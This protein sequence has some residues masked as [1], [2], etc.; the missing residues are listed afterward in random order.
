MQTAQHL[1]RAGFGKSLITAMED[2][3]S[4]VAWRAA[5]CNELHSLGSR[6]ARVADDIPTSFPNPD[7][8]GLYLN[9]NTSDLDPLSVPVSGNSPDLASLARFAEEHFVWGD[10]CGILKKFSTS[11][12]PG[13][14]VR[15]LV[16][17]AA[18]MDLGLSGPHCPIIDKIL[19]LRAP[20]AVSRIP[21]M[22]ILLSIDTHISIIREAIEGKRD[23]PTKLKPLDKWLHSKHRAWVPS[24]IMRHVLPSL[25]RDFNKRSTSKLIV[26]FCKQSLI[27]PGHRF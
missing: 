16:H 10:T 2:G 22:R 18:A 11:I 7:I 19:L 6:Q 13:L 14:A 25:V 27:S 5:L 15:Q 3:S 24:A 1:A 26:F 12:L 20:G 9:P 23:T 21:E 17:S 4:L 8:I